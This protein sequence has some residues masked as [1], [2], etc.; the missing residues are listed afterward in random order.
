MKLYYFNPK[1]YG[2]EAF[3]MAESK[4]DAIG[5]LEKYL[6]EFLQ[7][8]D[9]TIDNAEWRMQYNKDKIQHMIN[10]VIEEHDVGSIIWSEIC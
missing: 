6:E 3:V 9:T 7:N 2:D 4:E 10:G 5:Y 8:F 1:G